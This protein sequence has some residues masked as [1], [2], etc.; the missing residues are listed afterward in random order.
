MVRLGRHLEIPIVEFTGVVVKE[1]R[2]G[3]CLFMSM[4]NIVVVGGLGF[5]SRIRKSGLRTR[6]GQISLLLLLIFK[7]CVGCGVQQRS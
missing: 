7:Q 1:G 6:S 2:G 4:S 3:L 5:L